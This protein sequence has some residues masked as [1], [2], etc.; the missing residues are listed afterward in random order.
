MT[1][2]LLGVGIL[3]AL[4][5]L[6]VLRGAP[7]VPSRRSELETAFTKLYKLDKRDVL[8][9]IGSGDGIVLRAAARRGARAIGYEIN[10]VLVFVSRM[11][12]RHD[13]KIEV[14]LADFWRTDFP[15]DTTI[16]YTFG[17]SRDIRRM[18]DKV[19][20]EASRLERPLQ[21]MSYGFVVP[22]RRALRSH[23]AYHLYQIDPLQPKEP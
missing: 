5:L 1:W 15:D 2:L 21:F 17:E 8:V 4:F 14:L 19:Q 16:V 11:L 10:P 18:Y 22:G 3:A 13:K 20:R 6:T 7:Y 23:R 12:S 9:D